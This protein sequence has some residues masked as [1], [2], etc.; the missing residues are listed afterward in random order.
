[1][2][3]EPESLQEAIIYFSNR[4]NCRNYVVARRWPNGIVCPTCGSAKVK[5]Q[6]KHD[7]WQCGSHHRKRQFTIKT[8]TI[9]EDSALG[10]DKWLAAMWLVVNCKN[11][12]SSYEISRAIGVT[13]KTAWFMDH[14][15]RLAL[16]VGSFDKLSGEIEVDET[17][18]GGKARNM[19][20]SK[21]ERPEHR[22]PK[23]FELNPWSRYHL[24]REPFPTAKDLDVPFSSVLEGALEHSRYI[25]IDHGILGGSPRIVNTRIPVYMILDAIEF[26]GD[27]AGAIKS[28]PELTIEQVRDAVLFASEVLECPCG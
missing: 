27:L 10:M 17:F 18:I 26:H 24:R 16:H 20:I 7:R 25:R 28:Y 1:M 8:G 4:E 19:H 6:E 9:F 3:R 5:F 13:Q 2:E 12:I 15:I 14:R 22:E 11:G 21:R 23:S